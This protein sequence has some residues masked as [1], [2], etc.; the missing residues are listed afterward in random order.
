MSSGFGAYLKEA[1]LAARFPTPSHF[2]RAVGTDPSVVLRWLSEEQ[3]P[4]ITSIERI[5]PVLGRS[6]NELVLAAYP[7]RLSGPVPATPAIHPLVHELGRLL[8]DD[9]PIPRADREALETVLD[10]LLDPY[11]RLSRR[12]KSG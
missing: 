7:D 11:R 4:T 9:S 5:A 6:I 2:A 12:R 8:A 3:R 1:I 10:R